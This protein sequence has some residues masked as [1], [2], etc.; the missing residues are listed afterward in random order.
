M[1]VAAELGQ[2]RDRRDRVIQGNQNWLKG[3]AQQQKQPLY[4]LVIPALGIYLASFSASAQVTVGGYGTGAYG[5]AP[6]GT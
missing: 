4:V 5:V 3:L 6:Y 1:P 2:N